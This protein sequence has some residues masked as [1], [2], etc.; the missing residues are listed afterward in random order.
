[1]EE[2]YQTSLRGERR[3]TNFENI[4]GELGPGIIK[5]EVTYGLK[6]RKV[7]GAD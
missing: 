5:D 3:Q 2:L 1:M 6:N 7:E 4:E